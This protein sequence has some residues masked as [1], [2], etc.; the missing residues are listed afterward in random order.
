GEDL[1]P[2]G[3]EKTTIMLD[4]TTLEVLVPLENPE[5]EFVLLYA[6][7][8]NGNAEFYQFD[9]NENTIQRFNEWQNVNNTLE[10]KNNGNIIVLIIIILAFTIVTIVMTSFI[11]RIY[12]QKMNLDK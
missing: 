10:N 7:S 3:Y 6:K 9:K 12:L 8:E 4:S 5:S 2:V 11:I 1:I